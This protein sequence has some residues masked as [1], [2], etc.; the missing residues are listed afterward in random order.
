MAKREKEKASTAFHVVALCE[1]HVQTRTD[2]VIDNNSMILKLVLDDF[3]F[4]EI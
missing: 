2:T 3:I 4:V 1:Y